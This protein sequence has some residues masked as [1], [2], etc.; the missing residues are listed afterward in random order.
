MNECRGYVQEYLDAGGFIIAVVESTNEPMA[1]ALG[2][3]LLSV[4][5]AA[6]ARAN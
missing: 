5:E 2:E 4:F 6:L 1:D 3:R